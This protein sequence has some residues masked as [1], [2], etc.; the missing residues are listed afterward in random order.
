M[1]IEHVCPKAKKPVK[2][3]IIGN[4]TIIQEKFVAHDEGLSGLETSKWKSI[5]VK[6]SYCG[7]THE[8][9]LTTKYSNTKS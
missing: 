9:A 4:G 2:G 1:I 3:E 6:C 7:E 5:I 8:Y